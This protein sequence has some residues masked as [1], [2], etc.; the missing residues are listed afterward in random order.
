MPEITISVE[1]GN[2]PAE[3][4]LRA[5]AARAVEAAIAAL[6]EAERA[7]G[8][9]LSVVFTD[10]AAIQMLNKE[11]RGKDGPTN[12]LS[13]PQESA[14]P[15]ESGLLGDIVLA[16]E[17]VAREA[18]LA[19]KPVQ[20]HIA[21][22]LVHGFLHLLGYDHAADDEAEKMEELERVALGRLGIA[23]PYATLKDP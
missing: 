18:A 21:H 20:D 3:P 19:G 5:L 8:G 9:E 16:S 2:W 14:F 22:L 11:W 1:A 6:R 17:T 7:T 4:E 13:F 10:D 15:Q 12:V 23:D